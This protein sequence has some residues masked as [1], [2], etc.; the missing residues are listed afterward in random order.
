MSLLHLAQRLQRLASSEADAKS[1]AQAIAK[2]VAL[3]QD[4]EGVTAVPSSNFNKTKRMERP[5][6]TWNTFEKNGKQQLLFRVYAKDNEKDYKLIG[7]LVK[8]VKAAMSKSSVTFEYEDDLSEPGLIVKTI[9]GLT[10]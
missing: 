2:H 8:S 1:M 3:S 7:S 4:K 10:G 6:L 9:S 5:V